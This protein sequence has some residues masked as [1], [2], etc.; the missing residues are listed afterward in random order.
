MSEFQHLLEETSGT[1]D[2]LHGARLTHAPLSNF[3]TELL[4]G[5][6]FDLGMLVRLL[7]RELDRRRETDG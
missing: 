3:P 6:A 7:D 5:M 4:H 2:A 1:V